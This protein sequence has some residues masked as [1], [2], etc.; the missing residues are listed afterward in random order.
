MGVCV[1]VGEG[2]VRVG[3]HGAGEIPYTA[4]AHIPTY[5]PMD[6]NEKYPASL[7]LVWHSTIAKVLKSVCVP[8][9]VGT[10]S[11]LS[12]ADKAQDVCLSSRTAFREGKY[13]IT[14]CVA[15]PIFWST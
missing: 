6:M 5:V 10:G 1:G 4:E 8:T 11:S 14:A 9:L 2:K 15:F 12:S 13:L 3:R 7:L